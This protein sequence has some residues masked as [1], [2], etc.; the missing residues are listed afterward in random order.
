MT[1]LYLLKNSSICLAA[2]A[3]LNLISD[4]IRKNY[5]KLAPQKTEA[6]IKKNSRVRMKEL[7]KRHYSIKANA[8]YRRTLYGE[9][10]SSMWIFPIDIPLWCPNMG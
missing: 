2:N 5:L 8:L 3:S 1:L 9:K 10:K 4:W 7:Y 6:V